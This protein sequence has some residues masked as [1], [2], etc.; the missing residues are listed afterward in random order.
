MVRYA[1]ANSLCNMPEVLLVPKMVFLTQLRDLN[2]EIYLV[3]FGCGCSAGTLSFLPVFSFLSCSESRL[4]LA[5]FSAHSSE[6]LPC[7]PS[8]LRLHSASCLLLS[9]L[10]SLGPSAC[11]GPCKTL[12]SWTNQQPERQKVCSHL[13]VTIKGIS[14][15]ST[16]SWVLPKLQKN[17]TRQSLQC[18]AMK[19]LK[20]NM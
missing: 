16:R 14:Q 13:S 20:T 3:C 18:I 15:I 17:P 5:L 7:Q 6:L 19:R 10:P 2:A 12:G 4:P 1:C 11:S 9:C 8:F